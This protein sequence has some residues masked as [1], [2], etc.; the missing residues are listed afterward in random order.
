MA[1]LDR[2]RS[3]LEAPK[4]IELVHAEF[5]GRNGRPLLAGTGEIRMSSLQDFSY[6]VTATTGDP[7]EFFRAIE[8]KR[9]NRYDGTARLRL[10]GR[11]ANG[12]EWS[13][14]WTMPQRID[15]KLC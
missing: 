14:G 8:H 9:Q 11:D 4:T 12:T 5:V 3:F 1:T 15:F 13:G 6:S 2:W 10:F 7:I